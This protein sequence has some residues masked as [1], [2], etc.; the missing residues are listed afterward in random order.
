VTLFLRTGPVKSKG[1]WQNNTIYQED[2]A[3]RKSRFTEQQIAFALRQAGVWTLSIFDNE[4][5]DQGD[6]NCWCL[7]ITRDAQ[8]IPTLSEWSLMAMAGILGIAGFMVMRRR[9]V[10]A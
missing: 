3:M 4:G 1:I 2:F 10:T 6:L 7:E 5:G 9:K 8:N